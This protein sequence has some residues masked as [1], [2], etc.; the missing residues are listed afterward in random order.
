MPAGGSSSGV[1][2]KG[3][4][5]VSGSKGSGAIATSCSAAA[6]PDSDPGPGA[7]GISERDEEAK[8]LGKGFGKSDENSVEI[9]EDDFL[10]D[11]PIIPPRYPSSS[12]KGGK[13]GSAA[14]E[15][16][17]GSSGGRAGHS[18]GLTLSAGNPFADAA[19]KG[20]CILQILSNAYRKHNVPDN[21]P[22]CPRHFHIVVVIAASNNACHAHLC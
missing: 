6:A 10:S 12:S 11:R 15:H 2:G 18:K 19:F 16:A 7:V 14:S 4:G 9:S 21:C 3:S 1:P 22:R 5:G 8:D 20:G 13:A 17:P